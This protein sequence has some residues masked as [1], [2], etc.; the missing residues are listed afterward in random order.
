ML[1]QEEVTESSDKLNLE[2]VRVEAVV[3][4]VF[5]HIL[6]D[7]IQFLF[8]Y[9]ADFAGECL[10]YHPVGDG[11]LFGKCA[12]ASMIIVLK[13]EFNCCKICIIIEFLFK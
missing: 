12:P 8:Q 3:D 13:L 7:N 9:W 11:V 5:I 6:N 10:R 4:A 2:A 1:N